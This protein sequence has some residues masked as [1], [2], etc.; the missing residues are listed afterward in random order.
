MLHRLFKAKNGQ[1]VCEADNRQIN[2]RIFAMNGLSTCL[3]AVPPPLTATQP[4]HL[5]VG[6]NAAA[7]RDGI[8]I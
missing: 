8:H 1:R 4:P 2:R 6:E 7:V 3:A 5:D